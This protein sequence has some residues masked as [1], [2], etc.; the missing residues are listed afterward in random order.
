[1]QFFPKGRSVLSEI[2]TYMIDRIISSKGHVLTNI[3]AVW[4][5]DQKI[6]MLCRRLYLKGSPYKRCFGFVD[7]TVKA[8]CRP[9]YSQRE[10]E[11]QGKIRR[12]RTF[13]FHISVFYSSTTG[14]GEFIH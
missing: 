11:E 4:L 8:I 7:G 12:Y 3:N 10:V 6:K 2:F 1:M 14:T 13:I 9:T 5:S